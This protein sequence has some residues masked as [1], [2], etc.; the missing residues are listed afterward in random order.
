M[1]ISTYIS[2]HAVI[3]LRAEHNRYLYLLHLTFEGSKHFVAL[4]QCG[5]KLS[6]FLRVNLQLGL[7]VDLRLRLSK[8]VSMRSKLYYNYSAL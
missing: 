2:T 8:L 7:E 6:I 1:R 5:F 3:S 4:I